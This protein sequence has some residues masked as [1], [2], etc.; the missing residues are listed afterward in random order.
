[1]ILRF[2]PSTIIYP[3]H[4]YGEVPYRSLG[5]EARSNPVLSART[6]AEFFDVP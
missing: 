3:G 5:E 4:D 2:P 6:Y 1:M